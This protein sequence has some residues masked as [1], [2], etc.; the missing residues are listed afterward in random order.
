MGIV[1]SVLNLCLI[2][3][4][5]RDAG[6][7]AAGASVSHVA[8]VFRFATIALMLLV[9]IWMTRNA[10]KLFGLED[11]EQDTSI[12][13]EKSTTVTAKASTTTTTK[14]SSTND[15]TTAYLAQHS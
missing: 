15:G 13:L 9:S 3:A 1:P 14:T 4:A 2:G 10:K 8:S 12:D 6:S 7:I 5:A 11:I